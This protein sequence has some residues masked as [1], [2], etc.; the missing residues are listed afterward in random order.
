MSHT[1][2][3]KII[4]GL[5]GLGCLLFAALAYNFGSLTQ[6]AKEQ[7]IIEDAYRAYK[8]TQERLMMCKHKKSSVRMNN[9]DSLLDANRQDKVLV[10]Q[11]QRI[12]FEALEQSRQAAEECERQRE[13]D[14]EERSR[15]PSAM[16]IVSGLEFEIEQLEIA[17][18]S[19]NTS[20]IKS[21]ASL[22]EKV[23]A[24]R[25]ENFQIRNLDAASR[26]DKKETAKGTR[27]PQSYEEE[28]INEVEESV[29]SRRWRLGQKTG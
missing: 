5:S 26:P 22:Q 18:L 1:L 23:R 14:L 15:N 25:L 4:A 24:L 8:T 21:R 12:S 6:G 13:R 28:E 17:L 10:E 16:E 27:E 3:Q 19:V 2:T 20:K 7:H 9:A 11:E 29:Q